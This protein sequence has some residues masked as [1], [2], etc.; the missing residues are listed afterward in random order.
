VARGVGGGFGRGIAA[1]RAPIHLPQMMSLAS[2]GS[3]SPS[4]L[5]SRYSLIIHP[6]ATSFSLNVK[7]DRFP[8]SRLWR[9]TT[10]LI[11]PSPCQTPPPAVR[12][13]FRPSGLVLL[14][15]GRTGVRKYQHRCPSGLVLLGL[16]APPRTCRRRA[17]TRRPRCGRTHSTP[18]MA[19]GTPSQ[20]LC[21]TVGCGIHPPPRATRERAT[22]LERRGGRR[23]VAGGR[24]VIRWLSTRRPARE[25]GARR[26][27]GAGQL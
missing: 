3:G 10:R 25:W 17:C 22:W 4:S 12:D 5:S 2:S 15:L 14:V 21:P 18:P 26:G 9:S 19:A 13:L 1:A 20:G 6:V 8:I 27:A 11:L 16:L 23:S 24:W 7:L